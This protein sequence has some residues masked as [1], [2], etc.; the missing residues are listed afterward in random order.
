MSANNDIKNRWARVAL[1]HSGSIACV[2]FACHAAAVD[3][4][5]WIDIETGDFSDRNNGELLALIHSEISEALEGVRKDAADKHLP[6]RK[7]VEVELADAVIRI[8]DMAEVRGLDLAGAIAE[9][10]EY[11][12]M[13]ADHEIEARKA[14]NGKKF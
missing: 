4:G 13:R 8:M 3:T 9:K 11:N 1:K 14:A 6:H 10:L 7:M 5:W 12:S 2:Q